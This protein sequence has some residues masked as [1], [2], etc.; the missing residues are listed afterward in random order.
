M[1]TT[2]H[3]H[4]RKQIAYYVVVNLPFLCIPA[5]NAQEPKSGMRIAV[6][7]NIHCI[8]IKNITNLY[9]HN[10]HIQEFMLIIF[11]TNVAEEVGNQREFYFPTSPNCCFCTIWGN[12]KRRNCGFSLKCCILFI[13]NTR[14]ILKISPGHS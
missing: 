5:N 3:H 1:H 10:S 11:G 6:R 8:P 4:R 2:T 12:R 14:N 7:G 9:R 13:I